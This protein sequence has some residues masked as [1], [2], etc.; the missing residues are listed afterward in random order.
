MN[1]EK[2]LAFATKGA[3]SNEELRILTLLQAFDVVTFPFNYHAKLQSCLGIIQIAIALK[4][5]LVVMEGTGIAGGLACLYL[6]LIHRIP[7]VFSSGDAI[8]PFIGLKYPLLVPIF[9]LYEQILCQFCAGFIG[10]TPYLVGRSLTLGAPKAMTAAGWAHFPSSSEQLKASRAEIRQQ[11][12]IPDQA[13]VFGLL[14]SLV[15]NAR[16]QYCYGY[17]LIQA[18]RQINRSEVCLL[19]VGDGN[20]LSHL[21]TLAGKD[22]NQSVFLPGNVPLQQ[23][24]PYLSAIDVA[25]LPQS[26]DGVG[27]FRYTTKISEYWAANLPMA[28]SQTPM[29]YDICRG[30]TWCLPGAKPW[31]QTYIASLAQVMANLTQ[32]EIL[33]KKQAIPAHLPEFDQE[34][35]VQ[36]V[37][38]FI[39]DILKDRFPT[40]DRK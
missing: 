20:G 12:G 4:P 9:A 36:R 16:F 14:G 40:I 8:A 23:V 35:Q 29:A 15:W 33:T 21:K 27:S 7:Y 38:S 3:S 18:F 6:A 13:L 30:W 2:I 1:Q 11:L 22:L 37:S 24:I 17:E 34:Q 19:I 10:W 39:A 28:I 31:S 25:S 5:K 26:V 32:A